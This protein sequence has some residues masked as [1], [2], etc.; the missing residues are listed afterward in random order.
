[1]RGAKILE[2][3]FWGGLTLL[4]LLLWSTESKCQKGNAVNLLEFKYGFHLPAGDLQDRFGS[5]SDIGM[6]IQSVSLAKKYFFGIEGMYLFGNNVN[7]D[8]LTQLRAYDG[9]II[10][11]DGGAGDI[12]LKERGFYI[13]L[14]AGKIIPTSGNPK[15]L[16]GVRIQ[17]GGGLLQHKI[18]VQDNTENIVPLEK[19]Y[20]QGYD[21]LSNGPAVHLGLGYQYQSPTNNFQFHVMGDL[22]GASTSSR[23]NLDYATGTYLD[24]QRT[25]ILGGLSVAYIVII[26]R[27]SKPENIYY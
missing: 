19:K 15:K 13:G 10:G 23:R 6:S 16:T 21:R 27:S 3:R 5:N 4:L 11:I 24:Q 1:M 20:L 14:N 22:Y 17:I 8:V 9:I 7:E 18:R 26:S 2:L 25:D 12:N